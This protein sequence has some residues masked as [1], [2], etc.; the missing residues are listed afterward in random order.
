MEAKICAHL[1]GCIVPLDANLL[2]LMRGKN[3]QLGNAL[4]GIRSNRLQQSREVASHARNGVGL[5]QVGAVLETADQTSG[6]GVEFKTQ[7]KFDEACVYFRLGQRRRPP[8]LSLGKRRLQSQK[9]LK[10]R[11]KT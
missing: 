11:I 2:T 8:I 9:N 4:V 10:E 3:W 1:C 6:A 5:D 7:D